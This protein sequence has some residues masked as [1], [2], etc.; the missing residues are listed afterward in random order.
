[1]SNAKAKKIG[2]NK[3]FKIVLI[4]LCSILAAV[5]ITG[6]VLGFI[7]SAGFSA[8]SDYQYVNIESTAKTQ[9]INNVTTKDGNEDQ[10]HMNSLLKDGLASTKFSYL[11]AVMEGNVGNSMKFEKEDVEKKDED[12]NKYTE[13]EKVEI[14]RKDILGKITTAENAYVLTFSYKELKTITVE[15]EE[16]KFDTMRVLMNAK[17]GNIIQDYTVY[18]YDNDY[19]SGNFEG[20]D[21]YKITPVI[22][23]AKGTQFMEKLDDIF[24]YIK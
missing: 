21:E 22:V 1:M 23:K 19:V 5:I 16:I 14:M 24:K 2:Q 3:A 8:L 10:Y 4:V 7:P 6:T 15:G 18:F 20:S 12:G 11:R 9:S 13:K 17:E